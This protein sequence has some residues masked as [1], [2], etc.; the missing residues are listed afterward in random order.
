MEDGGRI[1]PWIAAA[2]RLLLFTGA[3]L[4]EILTLRWSEVDFDNGLLR[5]PDSKT[6][7]KTIYL[8]PPAIEVLRTLPRIDG[9][10]HVIC[11]A[12]SGA[13]LVNLEKPWRQVRK[14]ADLGDVRLHDL[15]HTFASV[16]ARN[17]LSLP[18]IGALLGHSQPATT[19]RYAHPSADPLR[20]AA[21][22]IAEEIAGKRGR[23]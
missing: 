16:A 12:K 18:V 22:R 10:P 14:A 7:A 1:T 13:H 4:S 20:E 5:L 15:R 9:D 6:G 8:P 11:G 23:G 2:V 17:G 21:S 19:A 3:R